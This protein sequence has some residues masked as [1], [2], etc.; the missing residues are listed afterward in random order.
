M[1]LMSL[2]VAGLAGLLALAEAPAM[3]P[4]PGQVPGSDPVSR[5]LQGVL[6]TQS[7]FERCATRLADCTFTPCCP[8][9]ACR[10]SGDGDRTCR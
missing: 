7:T 4:M 10:Q 6:G 8:G 1:R 2:S 9:G 5:A 3:S